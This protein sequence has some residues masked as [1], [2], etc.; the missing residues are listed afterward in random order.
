M[1]AIGI[2]KKPVLNIGEVP[3]KKEANVD[4]ILKKIEGV[5]VEEETPEE[6]AER[7]RIE[8]EN[9]DKNKNTDIEKQ[10]EEEKNKN[11][12]SQQEALVLI[13]KNK[14]LEARLSKKVEPVEVTDDYLKNKYPDWEEMTLGEQR[15]TR[16]AEEARQD[17]LRANNELLE[18]NKKTNEFNND[19]QWSEKVDTFANDIQLVEQYPSLKGRI[20]E[21]KIFC[22]RPTRK[23]MPLEDLV[24]IFLFES[25]AKAP[26]IKRHLFNAPG[27]V[28]NGKPP[29]KGITASEAKILREQKPKLYNK[30]VAEHKINIIS[31]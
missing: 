19:R 14:E 13:E 18:I 29:Q 31:G 10:L 11:K 16:I 17:S 26:E 20:D 24:K 5:G 15:A 28:N 8:K 22:N 25:P 23:G 4:E 7:E 12:A 2:K 30:L 6:K 9:E 1:T 27:G 21:L 3:V